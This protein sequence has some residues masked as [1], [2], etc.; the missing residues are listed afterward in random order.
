M[1]GWQMLLLLL[2][3]NNPVF[4]CTYM[5]YVYVCVMVVLFSRVCAVEGPMVVE[6]L[7]RGGHLFLF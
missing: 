3:Q 7:V 1:V 5:M 6:V 4:C 2:V